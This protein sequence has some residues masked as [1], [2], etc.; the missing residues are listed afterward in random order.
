MDS[1]TWTGGGVPLH[2]SERVISYGV[3]Y[4][5]IVGAIPAD[6]RQPRTIMKFLIKEWRRIYFK[7]N[8]LGKTLRDSRPTYTE[9]GNYIAP[10]AALNSEWQAWAES[11]I[12][13]LTQRSGKYL[14]QCGLKMP[15]PL[16][17]YDRKSPETWIS[18]P[19]FKFGHL[20]EKSA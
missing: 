13:S 6:C 14:D 1:D 9:N 4:A 18:D 10:V 19:S 8:E 12:K 7:V 20:L 15:R 16:W 17:H 2:S 11:E 5:Y 3:F